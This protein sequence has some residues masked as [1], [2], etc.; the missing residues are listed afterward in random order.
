MITLP[1]ISAIAAALGVAAPLLFAAPAAE[2]Q[3]T[4][5]CRGRGFVDSVYQTGQGGN[6]FEYFVIIRN[7]T[8]QPMRWQL[9]FSSF[10]SNVTLFSPQLTG[11]TL[12]PNASETIRFGRGT[13]GNINPGT[14]QTSY[15]TPGSGRPTVTMSQCR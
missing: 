2:A 4:T 14:V 11:G 7:Q 13:N 5:T 1:R 15:D 6:N 10:P 12:A 3:A 8:P 9:N